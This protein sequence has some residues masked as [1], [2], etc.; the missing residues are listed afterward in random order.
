MK[1]AYFANV[2]KLDT[3][4]MRRSIRPYTKINIG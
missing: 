3:F 2:N 4:D 1:Q